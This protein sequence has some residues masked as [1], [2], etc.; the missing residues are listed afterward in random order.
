VDRT[1]ANARAIRRR[2]ERA[3]G[4]ESAAAREA[5]RRL[6]TR[7]EYARL[8][9]T[10]IL[11]AG[12]GRGEDLGVLSE[13]YPHAEVV[14]IDHAFDVVR[15][16]RERGAIERIVGW[17]RGTRRQL[18]CGDLVRLPFADGQFDLVWSNLALSWL[19]DPR[20]ALAEFSRVM[21]PGGLLSFSAYGP[22]TLKELR[23]AFARVDSAPHVHRFLDMHDLGDLLLS[24]GLAAPVMDVDVVTFTYSGV[25]S[26]FAELR[27]SG[28]TNVAPE[29]RRGLLG[30]EA[31]DDVVRQ[32]EALRV[33]GR[34]PATVEYVFAHA[35]K[36]QP[37]RS[38]GVAPIRF[39]R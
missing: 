16:G 39:H 33:D 20:P 37:G 10:R 31:F 15:S 1:L 4:G 9:P 2:F 5:S 35:W 22:D 17:L 7:L 30:R 6:L 13:R 36:P 18:L 23:A 21:R 25:D 32:Y 29:R 8:E 34:V 12:C 14:G 11:D 27:D 26:L 38:P 24:H 3:A 19:E 28:Q